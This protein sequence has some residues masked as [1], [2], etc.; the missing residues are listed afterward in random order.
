MFYF[1]PTYILILPALI[2]SLWAS[3]RVNSTFSKYEKN[4]SFRGYTGA[5]AAREILN[6][7]G[8]YDVAIERVHGRLSDHYDPRTNVIRLSDAVYNSTS[9]AAI[10]VACHEAGHA[11]QY[12]ENYLPIKFRAMIIPITNIGSTFGIWIFII[13]LLLSFPAICFIG[14]ILFSFTA[15]FQ[16][17][18]LPTEFNASRRAIA[19]IEESNILSPTEQ[20]GAKKV[21]KAAALTYVAALAV[22]LTQL[23]RLL[24]LFGNTRRRN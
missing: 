21:L 1:D 3:A 6:A 2:F 10:G 9:T 14:I 16:L 17:A 4:Y 15:I 5:M 22:S 11:M 7:K 19:A 13:G 8:L 20:T 24:I 12:A 23:L 18:T